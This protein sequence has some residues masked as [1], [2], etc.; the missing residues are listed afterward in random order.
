LLDD[1]VQGNPAYSGGACQEWHGTAW[2]LSRNC[3]DDTE[4]VCNTST[5]AFYHRLH[6]NVFI[7]SLD[8]YAKYG[9][10]AIRCQAQQLRL[11]SW[12]RM[13]RLRHTNQGQKQST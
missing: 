11:R 8:D 13:A 9:I 1:C 5:K 2:Q 4:G 12:G 3:I 7:H 10:R 6:T